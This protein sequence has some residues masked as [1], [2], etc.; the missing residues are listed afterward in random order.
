MAQAGA[1][2]ESSNWTALVRWFGLFVGSLEQIASGAKK[3]WLKF[4]IV[5]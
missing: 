4:S 1:S 5:S 2:G 3:N